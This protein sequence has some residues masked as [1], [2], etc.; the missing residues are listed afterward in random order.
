M[1]KK[2]FTSFDVAVSVQELKE[3]IASSRVNNIYQFNEKTVILKL[4][5]TDKPP[6]RLVMEAGRRL[7]LTA[8][9][10]KPPK[11]P[12]AFCMALRKHL[13][14]AWVENVEQYEFER[15]ATIRFKTKSGMM[16]LILELF[17]ASTCFQTYAR[18][19]H[20]PQRSVPVSAFNRQKPLPSNKG[21]IGGGFEGSGRR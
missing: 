8:Y 19:Q 16:R 10:L 21:R 11:V 1:R 9:A 18:P 17:G 14:G 6:L 3:S 15:V 13:R 4:H 5:K 7:H 12:P 20:S 2:E